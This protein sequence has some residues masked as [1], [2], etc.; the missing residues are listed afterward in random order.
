MEPSWIRLAA[1]ALIVVLVAAAAVAWRRL[2]RRRPAPGAAPPPAGPRLRDGLR[3][4]RT[5]LA[6]RLDA[7]LRGARDAAAVV[8]ALEE[9]LIAADVGVPTTRELLS[10]VRPLAAADDGRGLRAG[11]RSALADMLRGEPPPEPIV[12]PWVVLVTGVNGVGKTTT[13]GKLAA[14][15][16]AAGRSV[17]LIAGDTFRAAAI[18]QLAVWADR[19]G[20]DIVRQSQGANAAAVVFDG[21]KAAVARDVAVV[22]VDSA[23]RLHT[24]SNLM[25]ELA[26]VRRVIERELPG[27]PHETLLVLDATTGQNAIAQARTFVQAVGV[28]GIVL[29]KLDGTARGGVAVAIRRELGIPIRWIGVG[30][31]VDDLRPFDAD[32]FVSALLDADESVSNP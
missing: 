18:D 16:R 2:A 31:G 17:M 12:R 10:R 14:R 15:H 19:A 21:I 6:G 4:T 13:I 29:T 22:L 7:V 32:E 3:A 1:A 25:E 28:T 23:G 27:A 24:R 26:K 5:R 8:P 9:T 30:E 20:A 11:L